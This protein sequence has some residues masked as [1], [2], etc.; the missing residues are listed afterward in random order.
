MPDIWE[1][2]AIA[3][4]FFLYLGV[5]T[6]GGLILCHQAFSDQLSGLKR[7]VRAWAAGFGALAVAMSVLVFSLRGGV[8]MDDVSGMTDPSILALLW[9]TPPGDALLLRLLGL[10]VMLVGLAVGGSWLWVA[11]FGSALAIWSFCEIGHVASKDR[12]WFQAVLFTHLIVAAFWLGVFLPLQWLSRSSET[13]TQA[14]DLGHRFG[15]I[16]SVTV[17]F[18]VVAG[19]IMTWRLVGSV[20]AMVGTSYGLM[21]LTKIGAVAVL[22]ALGA[23]NKVRLVP[24]LRDGDPTVGPRLAKSI[25]LEW[26]CV[27]VILLATAIFTSVLAVPT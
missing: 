7:F 5:L 16:A 27:W 25:S 11:A 17:P 15:Q 1:L 10:G 2:A 18:L 23:F 9:E 22:L 24:A 6:S 20:S 8:L 12:L 14:A 21:L 19:V 13:L 3:T 4:K 26:L